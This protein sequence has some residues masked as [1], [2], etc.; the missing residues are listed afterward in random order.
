MYISVWVI[1][2]DVTDLPATDIFSV[3]SGF[4]QLH[5]VGSSYASAVCIDKGCSDVL[6]NGIRTFFLQKLL[7]HRL[8]ARLYN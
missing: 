5:F 1:R 3:V 2:K 7:E 6:P 4:W 8:Q